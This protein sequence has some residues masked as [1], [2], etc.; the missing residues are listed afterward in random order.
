[1]KTLGLNI[2]V[3]N[4]KCL[5]VGGGY[6]AFRKVKQLLDAA[7]AV[8]VISPIV[9][10]ELSQAFVP[11]DIYWK[12]R[13]YKLGDVDQFILVIA[14]TDDETVNKKVFQD[15]S[16]KNIL[17]NIVDDPPKCSFYFPSVIRK[18][19]L[20]LTISS[21]GNAPFAVKRFR[22]LFESFISD[23]ND[24]WNNWWIQAKKLRQLA[25]QNTSDIDK[26]NKCFDLF[27]SKTVLNSGSIS[28]KTLSSDE[29]NSI[30]QNYL[31]IQTNNET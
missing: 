23:D 25:L 11:N 18:S 22:Q 6:V 17:C 21:G 27:F 31:S 19:D 16:Q 24:E 29:F 9:C 15:A 26:R 2:V 20:Q 1:M 30:V 14:A 4:K 7:A 10:D 5:V 3:E 28:L 12:K 13:K 8:T